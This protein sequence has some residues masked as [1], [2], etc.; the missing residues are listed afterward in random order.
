M[1]GLVNV[2]PPPHAQRS[3]LMVAKCLQNLANL[4]EFGAKVGLSDYQSFILRFRWEVVID[5]ST[6]GAAIALPSLRYI[7]I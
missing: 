5:G 4:I 6:R 7:E 1:W 2:I 3:L